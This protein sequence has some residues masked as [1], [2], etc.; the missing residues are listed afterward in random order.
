V[1]PF[2]GVG[3]GVAFGALT[4][5]LYPPLVRIPGIVVVA[6]AFLVLF[7]AFVPR[8]E[9][10]VANIELLRD[11]QSQPGGEASEA[12]AFLHD[13]YDG[14]LVLSELLSRANDPVQY[15]SR[16]A[17]GDFLTEALPGRYRAAL[18][19]PA[20]HADWIFIGDRTDTKLAQATESA[21]FVAAYK[22]AFE[23]GVARIYVKRD[24]P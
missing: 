23:N 20:G 22:L 13:H 12:A 11:V 21:S 2:V 5:L 16:L 14:G 24:R 7:L 4:L 8:W 6:G 18:D 1:V 17:T 10:P 9:H 15:R 19:D 3:L